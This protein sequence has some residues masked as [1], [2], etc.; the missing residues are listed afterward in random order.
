MTRAV[1]SRV[2]GLC[3]FTRIVGT[4]GFATVDLGLFGGGTAVSA[5]PA[6]AAWECL[7]GECVAAFRMPD[8]VEWIDAFRRDT[9]L[10]AILLAPSR[11]E[12]VKKWFTDDDCPLREFSEEL[13]KIGLEPDDLQQLLVGEVGAAVLI[14]GL[15][16]SDAMPMIFLWSEPGPEGAERWLAAI[17]ASLEDQDE[18]DHPAT[19]V[20]IQIEDRPAMLITMP[21]RRVQR[22]SFDL[23]EN[24]QELSEEELQ[25][26]IRE[27]RENRQQDDEETLHYTPMIVMRWDGR[28]YAA[29]GAK[30]REEPESGPDVDRM[31]ESFTKFVRAQSGDP[32]EFVTQAL[33][34]PGIQRV[35]DV[36]G[37][38]MFEC[39]INV[40]P[41]RELML[42]EMKP[43]QVVKFFEALGLDQFGHIAFRGTLDGSNMRSSL[44]VAAPAP[45]KGLPLLLDQSPTE[46]QPAAWVPS[47][48]MQYQHISFDLGVAY[49]SFK[50]LLIQEFG[51]QAST[52]FGFVETQVKG[53]VGTDMTG[54][55][56][57]IGN[58]HT[59][60][61]FSPEPGVSSEEIENLERLAVVWQ[62]RN[63]ELWT[64]VMNTIGELAPMSGRKLKATDEQG[65]R[66]W[67]FDEGGFEG[68]LVAGNGYLVFGV[69]TG[70][71]ERV[72]AALKN[73]PSG[74][75]ALLTHPLFEKA[76]SL[77]TLQPGTG[78][79]F[80]D[81]ARIA[82]FAFQGL[83]SV[84]DLEEKL[85]ARFSSDT[86]GDADG[87]DGASDEED[88][89]EFSAKH[90]R[91]ILP[92]AEELEGV[93]GVS[94]SRTYVDDHGLF[95]ESVLELPK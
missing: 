80:S 4:V 71:L 84:L 83:D 64:R 93:L 91:S 88:S 68:G 74:A 42:S 25:A 43:A 23:P 35:S 92:S 28:I 79:T 87:D 17:E 57:S 44:F 54:L 86:F 78:F 81:G 9:K 70:T 29:L 8:C 15:E 53:H 65:F 18:S 59:I 27:S 40:Q 32:G 34:N 69:G 76:Q 30:S 77:L 46:S 11:M 95:S 7:P 52:S 49:K 20:D 38:C 73:P 66:G 31:I 67:R 72:L 41:L 6:R 10:G 61:R 50:E 82:K 62:L 89:T 39:L 58:V 47:D 90:L 12:S 1:R 3:L 26:A 75:A 24:W 85:K 14:N 37:R 48:V 22:G 55:L 13:E 5:E 45:R 60:V 63:V 94:V 33:T 19:Q 21:G 2:A 36:A 56:S 16:S 51:Q